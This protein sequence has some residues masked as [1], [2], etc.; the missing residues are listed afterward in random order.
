[1][2]FISDIH[3]ILLQYLNM[4]L[5]FLQKGHL[6]MQ[7]YLDQKRMLVDRLCLVGFAISDVDLQLCILHGLNIEYDSLVVSL[8]SR[9]EVVPFNELTGLL[10]THEQ[11]LQ[12]HNISASGTSST[13]AFPLTL[14]STTSVV[15]LQPQANLSSTSILGLSPSSDQPVMSEFN[16]F[17]ASRGN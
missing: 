10:L 4:Q 3:L 14:A 16:V 2:S 6:F 11:R 5:H 17:I 15:P 1:M 8:N 9:S 7:T 13:H 12:K